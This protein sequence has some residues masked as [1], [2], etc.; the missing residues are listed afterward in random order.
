MHKNPTS[1]MAKS[2]STLNFREET[3]TWNKVA[4]GKEKVKLGCKL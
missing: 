4:K 1:D 2:E 3:R